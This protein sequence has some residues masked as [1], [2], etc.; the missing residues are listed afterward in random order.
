MIK[1]DLQFKCDFKLVFCPIMDFC[2]L[3]LLPTR[4]CP[5]VC[6]FFVD[7]VCHTTYTRNNMGQKCEHNCGLWVLNEIFKK[8]YPENL[9]K[10]VGA[11][12]KLPAK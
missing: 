9:R 5:A 1:C 2:F 10:I 3:T 7:V 4:L 8:I 6:R 12:W 11:L